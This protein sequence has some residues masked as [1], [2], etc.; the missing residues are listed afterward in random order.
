MTRP[1]ASC[2]KRSCDGVRCYLESDP[3]EV[4]FWNNIRKFA[5]QHR[6]TEEVRGD[7]FLKPRKAA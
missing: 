5:E 3:D 7:P 4:E 1:C 2:G 6:L